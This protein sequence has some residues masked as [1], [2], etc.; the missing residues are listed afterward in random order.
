MREPQPPSPLPLS[1]TWPPEFVARYRA[2]GHWRG[3]TFPAMLR[4]RG[5]HLIE[6]VI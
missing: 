2:A 5:P 4:E 3:D 6:A 1:Q